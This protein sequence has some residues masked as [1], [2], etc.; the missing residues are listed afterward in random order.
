VSIDPVAAILAAVGI[1]VAVMLARWQVR[2]PD[3]PPM[4]TQTPVFEGGV[5]YPERVQEFVDFLA[6]HEL[7]TVRLEV[8]LPADVTK[9]TD[10][11]LA[12]TSFFLPSPPGDDG[13]GYEISLKVDDA[14]DSP[15]HYAHGIWRLDSYVARR[16]N[17]IPLEQVRRPS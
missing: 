1:A 6:A 7:Q 14:K 5:D 2:R 11:W 10:T 16:L 12:S 13:E 8:W 4:G 9:P 17:P 15:L 3:A